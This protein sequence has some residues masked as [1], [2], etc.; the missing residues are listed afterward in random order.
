MVE[1]R[2]SK[3]RKNLL[4]IGKRRVP[5]REKMNKAFWMVKK[6]GAYPDLTEGAA[7]HLRGSDP[8]ALLLPLHPLPEAP[9]RDVL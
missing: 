4:E 9:V 5:P 2:M 3:M 1:V 7:G 6:L 8:G